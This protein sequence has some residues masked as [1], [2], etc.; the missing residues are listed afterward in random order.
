MLQWLVASSTGQTSWCSV[1]LPS[2]LWVVSATF[3]CWLIRPAD[4]LSHCL[5]MPLS[6]VSWTEQLMCCLTAWSGVSCQCCFHLVTGQTSW[7]A[8]S[9]PGQVRCQLSVLLS[10]VNWSDQLMC[11][12][13]AWSGVSC[14]CCFHLLTGQIGWCAVSLLNGQTGWCAVSLSGQVSVV[15]AA[16]TC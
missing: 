15:S 10:P 4:V 9:L 6:P 3:T 13:T 2:H 16:F 7:C 8:V 11:C 1:S 12:F 5:V 14:Q